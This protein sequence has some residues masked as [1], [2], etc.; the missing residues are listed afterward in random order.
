MAFQVASQSLLQLPLEAQGWIKAA[1]LLLDQ[2]CCLGKKRK[3]EK[4]RVK[5]V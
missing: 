5:S 1:C 3:E 4:N 2:S